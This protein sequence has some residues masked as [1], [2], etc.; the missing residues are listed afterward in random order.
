MI[1][2]L[3]FIYFDLGKVLVEFDLDQMLRQMGEATGIDSTDVL[4]ALM[5][6]G[7]QWQYEVGHISTREYYEAY[8]RHTGKRPDLAALVRASNEI[9]SPIEST[10]DLARSLHKSGRRL[11]ILSNTIDIHWEYCLERYPVLSECF[12]IH[13]LSFRIG[14]RKPDAAIYQAA[15][16]LADCLPEEIFFTDDLLENVE[17]AKTAGFAAVQYISTS[18]LIA[19][20]RQRGIQYNYS[21]SD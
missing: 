12:S 8:C 17:G 10:M 20:L 3:K 11:G 1:K 18:Q 21:S 13:A 7:L 15:A 16:K 14:A 19:E 5:E 6:S 4:R 2:Q 9:F